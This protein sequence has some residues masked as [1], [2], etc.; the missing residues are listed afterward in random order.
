MAFSESSA[1]LHRS[2]E[3]MLEARRQRY[4]DTLYELDGRHDP[5]HPQHARYTGLL[6]KRTTSLL[7][8]DFDL[9]LDGF[10]E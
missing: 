4:I 2:I 10:P 7:S 9:L 1:S 5:A 6:A 3:P 8:A